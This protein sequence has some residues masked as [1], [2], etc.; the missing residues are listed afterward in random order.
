LPSSSPDITGSTAFTEPLLGPDFKI[1]G[2]LFDPSALFDPRE[3]LFLVDESKKI[4]FCQAERDKVAQ[5][6]GLG[7]EICK[8]KHHVR[9]LI[10]MN[11]KEVLPRHLDAS[12]ICVNIDGINSLQE[13]EKWFQENYSM[14]PHA[15]RPLLL[16]VGKREEIPELEWRRLR[17]Q[18]GYYQPL[19]PD[20]KEGPEAL[21]RWLDQSF[22][23]SQMGEANSN[24]QPPGMAR[25]HL[26]TENIDRKEKDQKSFS[27]SQK[28]WGELIKIPV[29]TPSP[30]LLSSA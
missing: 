10:T 28:I 15:L 5:C 30:P 6:L 23:S 24:A 13:V 7:N 27:H 17:H 19:P 18:G 20:L 3:E 14:H 11:I 4:A 25:G 9:F 16:M 26:T 21:L 29:S 22:P 12:L 1:E 8:A 2:D